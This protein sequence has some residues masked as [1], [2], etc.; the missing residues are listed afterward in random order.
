MDAL[1][2]RRKSNCCKACQT[3]VR[4]TAG[5]PAGR[6]EQGAQFIKRGVGLLGHAGGQLGAGCLVQQ[7]RGA[8]PVRKRRHPTARPLALQQLVNERQRDAEPSGNLATRAV[9]SR[10]GGRDPFT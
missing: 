2:L 7:R 8:A 5:R 6:H 1:F 3:V 10:T 4:P 9:P